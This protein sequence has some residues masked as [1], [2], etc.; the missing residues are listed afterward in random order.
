M[1]WNGSSINFLRKQGFGTFSVDD[2][3]VSTPGTVSSGVGCG[4]DL[5]MDQIID[6]DQ[7]GFNVDDDSS[8]SYLRR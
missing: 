8:F 2:N 3:W 1:F 6:P 7:S 5:N 4:L